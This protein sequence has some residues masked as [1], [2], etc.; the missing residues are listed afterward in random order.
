MIKKVTNNFLCYFFSGFLV[1]VTISTNAS[2]APRKPVYSNSN[3][4]NSSSES[5]YQQS[6]DTVENRLARLE[7]LLESQSLVDL[8]LRMDNIQGELQSLR[9][10]VEL[11]S[12][13]IEDLKKRQRDLYIDVDRRLVQLERGKGVA[14]SSSGV[15]TSSHT[16]TFVSPKTSTGSGSSSSPAVAA[17]STSSKAEQ[18]LY[19]KAFN[20]LREL[21]YDKSIA[22][23]NQFISTY[24]TGRYA[25]I[26]QYWVGEANY[27]QGNYKAAIKAYQEL[28]SNYSKSPKIADAMLKV[29]YSYYELKD[30]KQAKSNL[31]QLIKLYPDTTEASQAKN[32]LQKIKLN[33]SKR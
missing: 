18:K 13:S 14:A 5:N 4:G 8:L 29:G 7:R 28:I 17:T 1:L 21:R 22:A 20:L 12:H 27:T 31:T 6:T 3:G 9:G 2:A 26:A 32:K 19:Q 23:F 15:T 16:S 11:I 30:I 24:P 33:H 10:D 25:H